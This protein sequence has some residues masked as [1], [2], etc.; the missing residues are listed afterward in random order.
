MKHLFIINPAAG[1]RDRTGYYTDIIEKT[2]GARGLDYEIAVS[3]GERGH[4]M[5]VPPM[6]LARFL[7][8]K[9][10]DITD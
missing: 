9:L 7:G 2:C 3:A 1:S 5:L 4:Q 10:V 6:D 8:A